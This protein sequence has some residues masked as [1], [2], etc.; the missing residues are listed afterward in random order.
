MHCAHPDCPWWRGPSPV[1]LNT[2]DRDEVIA[3]TA[4][5]TVHAVATNET[6]ELNNGG[7]RTDDNPIDTAGK[8]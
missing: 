2:D 6:G 1:A 8:A 5:A 3:S 7:K 4:G